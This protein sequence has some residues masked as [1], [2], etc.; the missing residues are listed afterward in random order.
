MR[1]LGL[2][3]DNF[4]LKVL[5]L[6]MAWAVWFMASESLQD[7]ATVPMVV[8]TEIQSADGLIVAQPVEG[9]QSVK[10]RVE[11][12]QGAVADFE[13]VDPV[14]IVRVK[15]EQFPDFPT[16]TEK[17]V[18]FVL[19]DVV[20]PQVSEFPGLRAVEM[21]PKVIRVNVQRMEVRETP[22]ELTDVPPLV[23]TVAVRVT[24]YDSMV[25]I[26]ATANDLQKRLSPIRASID[27]DLL[28]QM[29][30]NLG[31]E[32]S[33]NEEVDLTVDPAQAEMF[34]LVDRDRIRARLELSQI[35]EGSVDVPVRILGRVDG[36]PHRR[37]VF[38]PSNELAEALQGIYTTGVDGGP[39]RL[40]LALQGSPAAIAAVVPARVIAFVL[41]S[42]M[43]ADQTLA[44]LPL[45]VSGLPPGVRLKLAL[46]LAVEG[47]R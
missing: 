47:D 20:L 14:V 3:F 18:D 22:V 44:N 16:E 1:L 39:P 12:P 26:K 37:L 8:R 17:K 36:S 32:P 11:G 13:R 45:H 5:A 46:T 41:E 28:R 38:S 15:P 33:S 35:G 25:K 29:A 30:N 43:P 7:E 34:E 9:Y 31:E 2:V 19:D 42:E 10:V 6:C 23:G 4:G 40:L 27:V 21:E 24:R